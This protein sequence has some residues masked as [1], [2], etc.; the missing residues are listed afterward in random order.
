MKKGFY[1]YANPFRPRSVAAARVLCDHFAARGEHIYTEK[2]LAGLGVGKS[3]ELGEAVPVVRAVVA[4][5]GDGTLLRIAPLAAKAR[6]PLLGI[7]AGTVGFLMQGSAEDPESVYAALTAPEYTL[8]AHRLLKVSVMGQEYTVLNDVTV[9][10]GEHPGVI[11]ISAFAD[12]EWLFTA[13]GDGAAVSTPLGATAYALAA[14]GPILRP[15]TP[16]T[17]V[18]PICARELLLRPVLLPREAHVLLRVQGSPRRRLQCSLDGQKLLP[19]TEETAISVS[20]AEEEA[21]LIQL[22]KP[23]F[24]DTLRQK[25]M[26]WNAWKDKEQE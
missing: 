7:H 13:H 3:A 19:I 20:P 10:R 21:Q 26:Q 1:F 6:L 9:T 11:E 5:G 14:G 2:W 16:C 24:F 22:G 15:D 25:Q 8:A 23:H 17:L 18:T 4:I 12:S